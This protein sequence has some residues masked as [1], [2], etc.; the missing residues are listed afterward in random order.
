MKAARERIAWKMQK[1]FP[2]RE[3]LHGHIPS[4]FRRGHSER[5]ESGIE[6]GSIHHRCA[7]EP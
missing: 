6:Y 5:K 3:N 4:I 7:A 1:A 2:F